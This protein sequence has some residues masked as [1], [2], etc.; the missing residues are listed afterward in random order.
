MF[1]NIVFYFRLTAFILR[2]LSQVDQLNI[3]NIDPQVMDRAVR[4]IL[5]NQNLEGDFANTG[6]VIH[7]AMQGGSSSSVNALAAFTLTALNEAQRAEILTV[8]SSD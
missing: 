6:K 3:I 8:S 5:D 1:A 2:V 7:P 4:Y